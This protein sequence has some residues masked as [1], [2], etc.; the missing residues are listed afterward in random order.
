MLR[1]RAAKLVTDEDSLPLTARRLLQILGMGMGLVTIAAVVGSVLLSTVT[2]I[3]LIGLTLVGGMGLLG[4]VA[5]VIVFLLE[6]RRLDSSP[7]THSKMDDSEAQSAHQVV[8]AQYEDWTSLARDIASAMTVYALVYGA[9]TVLVVASA[10][11]TG[12][13][14]ANELQFHGLWCALDVCGFGVVM[15]RMLLVQQRAFPLVL[16]GP[17]LTDL[18]ARAEKHV[19]MA[20]LPPSRGVHTQLLM[21]FGTVTMPEASSCTCRY[22]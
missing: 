11:L 10:W 13:F 21:E 18:V 22:S 2:L 19:Q 6:T 1:I 15:I 7:A 17:T 5:L 4:M 14:Q 9:Q 3:P 12:T 16:H 20:Q 8:H